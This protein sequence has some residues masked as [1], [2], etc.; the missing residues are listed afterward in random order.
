MISV[1]CPVCAKMLR[2]DEKSAGRKGRCSRC[3]SVFIICLPDSE[4]LVPG[5]AQPFFKPGDKVAG[6]YKITGAAPGGR[7]YF[8]LEDGI[9]PRVLKVFSSDIFSPAELE[10]IRICAKK[11]INMKSHPRIAEAFG[12][13]KIS[14]GF[15]LVIEQFPADELGRNNLGHFLNRLS[16]LEILLISIEFCF[17]L[18]FIYS[19]NITAH[20]NIK[21]SNMMLSPDKSLSITDI[22]L[23]NGIA[24]GP[25]SGA[26]FT[27]PEAFSG[28]LT[29]SC[30]IYSF[31]VVLYQ[32]ASG[33]LLPFTAPTPG[34]Y[35][36]L[37]REAG[38]APLQSALFPAAEKCMAKNPEDRPRG[39]K[40]LREELW[41]VFL[42]SQA[43]SEFGGI[44]PENLD[45]SIKGYQLDKH[46]K[47]MEAIEC[48]DRALEIDSKDPVAWSRRAAACFN[49][50][51]Y[52]D[53]VECCNSSLEIN[54]QDGRVWFLKGVAWSRLNNEQAAAECYD[55]ALRIDPSNVRA[56]YVKGELLDKKC[57]YREAITC[58]EH[59]LEIDPDD[60]V[61]LT[62]KGV[63]L[64]NTGQ[65]HE[66]IECFGRALEINPENVLARRYL[67]KLG[68]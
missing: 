31:G 57:R 60:Y 49:L 24:P 35:E 53:A 48:Y 15:A 16:L 41:D 17:A 63:A 65:Y 42:K 56:W 55:Q 19:N 22:G 27:A 66:A 58:F 52:D 34:E 18:D 30:D 25:A 44:E 62:G 50:G 59:A 29:S 7:V 23:Y 6:R 39:F 3:G 68:Q 32:M 47:H 10:S 54:P 14:G 11:W 13:V 33:G 12:V 26:P 46:R 20:G 28:V 61:A 21:P 45:V 64:V 51:R 43:G 2:A 38:I 4:G 8:C 67:R 37:H 1:N 36:K 9:T 5:A 40:F